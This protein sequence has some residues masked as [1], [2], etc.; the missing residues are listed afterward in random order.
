MDSALS[1]P[2]AGAYE[3]LL[4]VSPD[5]PGQVEAALRDRGI[6]ARNVGLIP[7]SGSAHQYDGPLWTTDAISPNDLTGISMEYTNALQHLSP[8]T[9]WVLFENLNV[10]LLYAEETQVYRLVDFLLQKTSEA[11]L[12]GLYTV[13]RDATGDQTFARLQNRFDR[14]YRP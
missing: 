2:P 13:V 14:K 11:D 12:T 9:D 7:I 5:P 4:L 10:L 8:G 1:V 6:D 3:N